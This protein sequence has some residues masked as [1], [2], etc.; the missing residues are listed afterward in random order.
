M[1][2]KEVEKEILFVVY[3]DENHRSETGRLAL[4]CD[5][6]ELP[7]DGLTEIIEMLADVSDLWIDV[8]KGTRE[9][10][11]IDIQDGTTMN[12]N[13]KERRRV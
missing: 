1:V 3:D 12:I 5:L 7:A 9:A 4:S 10:L 6:T 2:N 11:F 8:L 13:R